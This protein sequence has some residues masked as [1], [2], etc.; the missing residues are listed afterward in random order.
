MPAC[1]QIM[2]SEVMTLEPEMSLRE[3]VDVLR[4]ADVTGAPVVEG[5]VLVGVVSATDLLEFE[6]TTAGVPT[7]RREMVGLDDYDAVRGWDEGD[8][9]P[10]AYFLDMW[11]DAGAEVFER[12]S[13]TDGPEWDRLEEHVV[14]EVMSR[15]VLSVTAGTEIREAAR[16]MHEARVHRVLVLDDGELAGIVTATDIVRAVAENLL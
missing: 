15:K 8:D 2:V 13:E 12:F 9:P 14:D 7:E 1:R 4:G 6:A 10:A 3:A 16:Y 5:G 11:S